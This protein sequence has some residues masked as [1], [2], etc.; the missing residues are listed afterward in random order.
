[1]ALGTGRYDDELSAALASIRRGGGPVYGGIL[2]V[3]AEPGKRGFAC[4][5]T[6]EILASLPVILRTVADQIEADMNGGKT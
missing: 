1:M 6:G 4:Q 2:I 3:F 5:A